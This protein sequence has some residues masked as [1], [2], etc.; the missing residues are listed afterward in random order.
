MIDYVNYVK[1]EFSESVSVK[2]QILQSES[3]SRKIAEAA[4]L[5]TN[6]YKNGFKAI[7]AG[8]G[9]SAA[10]S[11]HLAGELVSKFYY[12]RPGL[13]AIALTVD[14]SIMTAIGNDYGFDYLFKRQL[15]SNAVIGDVFIGITTSGN[16]SNII[17]ALRYCKEKGIKSI[18]FNGK[19]GGKIEKEN[20]ADI[21]IIIPSTSTPR[22]QESHLVIGHILC[23][24]IEMEMFPCKQS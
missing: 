3:I 19:D 20:L 24:I 17:E 22:I 15:E 13:P 23:A 9:G 5:L 7:F 12:D 18:C 8:N 1:K 6:A 21:N 14:S 11:Q 16:S 4:E 2:E 10:D